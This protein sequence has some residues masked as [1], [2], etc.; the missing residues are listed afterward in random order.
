[1]LSLIQKPTSARKASNTT[2]D[3]FANTVS[4]GSTVFA[5][6]SLIFQY[7]TVYIK[8]FSKCGIILLS[9][10]LALYGLKLATLLENPSSGFQTRSDIKKNRLL[11]LLAKGLKF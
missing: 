1:M 6:W 9:A 3:E 2:I 7:Y 4:S 5:L 11:K 8:S 10:F